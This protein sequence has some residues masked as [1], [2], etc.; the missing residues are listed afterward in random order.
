MYVYALRFVMVIKFLFR[1]ADI[2]PSQIVFVSNK[3]E[4]LL[5]QRLVCSSK[6]KKKEVTTSSTGEE[7]I[8]TI[9]RTFESLGKQLRSLNLPLSIN[10]IQG[11][12]PVLRGT[13]VAYFLNIV[14]TRTLKCQN[15]KNKNEWSILLFVYRSHVIQLR[16]DVLVDGD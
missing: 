16:S 1:H 7:E 13:E 9:I 5:E 4:S 11:L 14:F 12:S 3:L 2:D 8:Q 10:S 6:T 15:S